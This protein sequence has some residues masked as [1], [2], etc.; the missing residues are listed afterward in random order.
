MAAGK[1]SYAGGLI[2]RGEAIAKVNAGTR[3]YFGGRTAKLV[4]VA[5]VE[6][7]EQK[8]VLAVVRNLTVI[9]F[10]IV[11]G[12]GRVC[13][14]HQ[15]KPAAGVPLLSPHRHVVGGASGLGGNIHSRC[16]LQAPE[17]WRKRACC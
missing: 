7:T 14:F 10:V 3:T 12:N 8:A 15:R 17:R 6:S 11:V 16:G 9:N 1:T 2:R 5:H 4:S 13:A